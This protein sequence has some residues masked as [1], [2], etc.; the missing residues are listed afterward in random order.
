M[1][2]SVEIQY[3][4]LIVIVV[5]ECELLI[6]IVV[7]EY[8]LLIVI[9]VD[10]RELLIVIA[11]YCWLMKICHC[12]MIKVKGLKMSQMSSRISGS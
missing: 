3:V 8:V 11:V 1:A 4:L 9:V 5:D 7:D 12:R 10:E 6:V 2:D